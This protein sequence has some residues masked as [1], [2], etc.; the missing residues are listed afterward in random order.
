MRA[1]CCCKHNRPRIRLNSRIRGHPPLWQPTP[2]PC[3]LPQD[4]Q[5]LDTPLPSSLP[6]DDCDSE[7]STIFSAIAANAMAETHGEHLRRQ[8]HARL[9]GD[10]GEHAALFRAAE[11]DGALALEGPETGNAHR[12]HLA[13]LLGVSGG[14]NGGGG[15]GLR[16]QR[17][18]SLAST[19]TYSAESA[20]TRA[21]AE[22][23]GES[24]PANQAWW[25]NAT[26]IKAAMV[27]AQGTQ[28]SP[29]KR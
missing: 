8:S 13:K 12:A 4:R 16:G 17:H 19:L 21:G 11:R 2:P 5:A 24:P 1:R 23:T 6:G 22:V 18:T 26:S 28:V 14:G 27:S 3:P 9:A 7:Y 15:N 10:H 25:E 29:T 20:G